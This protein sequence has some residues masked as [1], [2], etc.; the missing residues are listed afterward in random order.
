ML[1][2]FDLIIIRKMKIQIIWIHRICY[3]SKTCLIM[4]TVYRKISFYMDI[5]CWTVRKNENVHFM[6]HF[7]TWCMILC[8]MTIRAKYTKFPYKRSELWE[9]G[10]IYCI[11][12]HKKEVNKNNTTD[13]CLLNIHLGITTLQKERKKLNVSMN[14]QW[15]IFHPV[16][17]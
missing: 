16:I 3:T 7:S 9:K 14:L 6:L 10:N 15:I 1:N 12:T 2:L 17:S 5:F 11:K 8:L 13:T 4:S